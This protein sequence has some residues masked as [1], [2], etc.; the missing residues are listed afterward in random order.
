M[1]RWFGVEFNNQAYGLLDDGLTPDSPEADRLHALYTA[2]ASA[3]HWLEA[4][5]AANEARG[6]YTIAKVAVAIGLPDVALRHAARCLALVTEHPDVMADWDAPFAHEAYARAL[7]LTGD[8][9]AAK[10]HWA[11][12]EELAAAV[13]DPG[14]REV[15]DMERAREPLPW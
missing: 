6:E 13:A 7:A 3:R 9:G 4:G 12:S 14:D 1:H 10:E 8:T 11:R 15:L 2:Y 5:N